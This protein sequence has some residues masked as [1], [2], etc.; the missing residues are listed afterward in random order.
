[1]NPK[2]LVKEIIEDIK[3]LP[4]ADI[5]TI[6]EFVDFIK[7]KEIEEDILSSKKNIRAVKTS[8]KAWKS[9][10][11]AEFSSWEE[12]KKKHHLC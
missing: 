3:T 7:D 4:A 5:K 6:A 1:M 12:L 2:I 10:K 11:L 8:R 9:K